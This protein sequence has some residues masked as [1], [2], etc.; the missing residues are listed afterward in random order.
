MDDRRD[1]SGSTKVKTTIELSR[2]ETLVTLGAA[3]CA[4]CAMAGP[5]AD[6]AGAAPDDRVP[7]N[8]AGK[9]DAGPVG[10]Y[11]KDGV[12]DAH[13]RTKQF[14]VSRTGDTI[15]AFTSIC[16]H[17]R[18]VVKKQ[19]DAILK[20]PCHQAE[21]NQDGIVVKKPATVSLK[22]FGVSLDDKGHLIVDTS[23]AFEEKEWDQPGASL[24]VDA[25]SSQPTQ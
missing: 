13:S 7:S 20:C 24:K 18:C 25:P 11:A 4:C 23:K 10:D 14:F 6:E 22:R 15:V 2:R 8:K 5:L 1:Q 17:R 16:S 3:A 21:F 9:Q 19:D 12:Y